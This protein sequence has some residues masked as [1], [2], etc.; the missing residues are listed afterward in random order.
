M[1]R[2]R[3]DGACKG[4]PGICSIGYVIYLGDNIIC[5]ESSVVSLNNT[6]NF[7]EY[8][9]VL[10]GIKHAIRLGIKILHIEGDS[11]L[12]IKQLNKQ[13]QIKSIN[14]IPLFDQ[15]IEQL[16]NFDDFSFTHIYRSKNRLADSLANLAIEKYLKYIE[17]N[18]DNTYLLKSK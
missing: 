15:I 5:N 13:Y 4:N 11:Q 16:I 14:L 2:L 12:V 3:F 1:Y 6:N 8:T 17:K 9:A 18:K 7:A 10:E